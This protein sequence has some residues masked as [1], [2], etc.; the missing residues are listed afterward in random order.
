MN[1]TLLCLAP[2]SLALSTLTALYKTSN[3]YH[4][5]QCLNQ[6]RM[7]QNDIQAL[8]FQKHERPLTS[9]KQFTL[10]F[11]HLFLEINKR[12]HTSIFYNLSTNY[13]SSHTYLQ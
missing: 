8:F 11:F 1:I 4:Y 2:L 10:E 13:Y 5:Y 9:S 6:G 7:G 3:Y 12:S